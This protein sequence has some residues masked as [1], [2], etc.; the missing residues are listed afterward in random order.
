M[1]IISHSLVFLPSSL[2]QPL[3][4][5]ISWWVHLYCTFHINGIILYIVFCVWLLS[6]S[7]MFSRFI[8]V[9][10][11]TSFP[12]LAASILL[13]E[14]IILF[15]LSIHQLIDIW[16]ISAFWLLWIMLL[17]SACK[18]GHMFLILLGIYLGVE[19]LD[20]M[21]ILCLTFWGDSKLF[22]KVAIPFYIFPSSMYVCLCVC[23]KYLFKFFAHL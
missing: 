16:D 13:Y 12:F 20:H 2:W 17:W 1:P 21:V 18:C 4:C 15:Y 19:L 6:L 7:I 10:A 5:F 8:H 22:T 14:C 23:V 9:V 3:I 11:C